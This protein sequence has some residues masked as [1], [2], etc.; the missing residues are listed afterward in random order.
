MNFCSVLSFSNT[1]V[2]SLFLN[3]VPLSM[4]IFLD[5]PKVQHMWS[6]YALITSSACLLFNGMQ[7][8]NPVSMHTAVRANLLPLLDA[9][10]N[11]PIRSIAMNS[12][13]WGGDEKC[14][15]FNCWVLMLCFAQTWQFVQ[16]WY[17]DFFMPFQWYLF[18]KDAYVLLNLLWPCL[19][20]ARIRRQSLR[21]S[22]TTMGMYNSPLSMSFHFKMLFSI[23]YV[24]WSRFLFSHC[25]LSC[26][27][28]GSLSCSL[29]S[30]SSFRGRWISVFISIGSVCWMF[31][32]PISHSITS[33]K[34][35]VVTGG[36]S[37]NGK[38]PNSLPS[39]SG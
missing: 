27:V 31:M 3:S 16:C 2:Q 7:N 23:V 33:S 37:S 25:F 19:S 21:M 36:S 15:F 13:G 32:L 28:C 11:S 12:I 35:C 29:A 38:Y 24:I 30:L 26:L 34:T 17:T 8:V 9:G 6:T 18:F 1:S 5:G 39:S 22:G 4:R 10:W 20:C 14:S